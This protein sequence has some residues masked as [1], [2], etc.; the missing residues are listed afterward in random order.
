M[1]RLKDPLDDLL[2]IPIIVC[3]WMMAHENATTIIVSVVTAAVTA[4]IVLK[5]RAP[6]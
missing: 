4:A 1:N 6:L 2:D 5:L 3:N